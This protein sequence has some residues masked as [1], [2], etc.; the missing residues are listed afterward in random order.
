VFITWGELGT[1]ES[2]T[3]DMHALRVKKGDEKKVRPNTDQQVG[4]LELD[5]R[6]IFM[7]P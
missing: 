2:G 5:F 4:P 7:T 6:R 1:G 3:L